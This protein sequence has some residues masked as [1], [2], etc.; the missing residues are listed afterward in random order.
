[1]LPWKHATLCEKLWYQEC[2]IFVGSQTDEVWKQ[3][4]VHE[5][6]GEISRG[7]KLHKRSNTNKLLPAEKF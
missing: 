1:M 5:R 6:S 7:P 4:G 2:E 3:A